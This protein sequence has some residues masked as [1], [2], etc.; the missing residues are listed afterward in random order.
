M[1]RRLRI[2]PEVSLAALVSACASSGPVPRAPSEARAGAQGFELRSEDGQN[3]LR[4]GGLFQVLARAESERDPAADFELKRMRP[5]FSGRLA[6]ALAFNLEPNFSD[7]DV[8]L[9]EAWIGPELGRF[10]G[11]SARLMLGRMKAPFGLEEVRSRRHIDF[12]FFSILNQFSPAEDHGLFL[13]GLSGSGGWEYGLAAYNGTGSS[14][15]NSSKDVAARLM[16][17]PFVGETGSALENLQLGLAATLGSQ[18]EDVGGDTLDNETQQPVLVFAGDAELDGTRARLG[19][20]C[21]WFRGPWFAQSELL[22][23]EQEMSA[24]LAEEDIAVRGGYLTLAR[25]LTGEDKTFAG[26]APARPF[27]FETGTGRGAWVLAAR[28]S[29]L[30]LDDDLEP[31]LVEPGTFTGRIQSASLGLNWVPN[32]HAIVRTAVVGSFYDDEVVIDGEPADHE[33]TLLVEFQ[34][35]F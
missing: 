29:L 8:E 31:A 34:L 14:D 12:P 3:A 25:V 2:L 21:A 13:N 33:E 24:T 30:D 1:V 32:A 6:G 11:G 16:C 22:A 15:T 9:E 28:Y 27:D 35:H 5:E 19:L 4:I 20:E 10:L 18:E 23:L 7:D 17:H 26:V